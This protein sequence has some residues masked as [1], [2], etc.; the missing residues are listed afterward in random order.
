M[1]IEKAEDENGDSLL[2]QDDPNNQPSMNAIGP[3][4]EFQPM[5]TVLDYDAAKSKR[6]TVFKG[7]LHVTARW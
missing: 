4:W 2:H 3:T 6:L 1:D 7:S 5:T